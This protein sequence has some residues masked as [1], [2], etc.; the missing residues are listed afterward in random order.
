[1]LH[2]V[3]ETWNFGHG[4]AGDLTSEAGREERARPFGLAQGKVH[5]AVASDEFTRLETAR[6]AGRSA[7]AHYAARAPLRVGLAA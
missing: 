6:L 7:P 1:M 4:A 2:L 5:R 3:V